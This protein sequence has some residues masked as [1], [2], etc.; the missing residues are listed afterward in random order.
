MTDREC[1]ELLQWA[2]PR[3]RLRWPGFRRV[4][5]Q[6]CKR[7]ARRVAV[8]GLPDTTA[9]RAHLEAN[10]AEWSALEACCWI[11]I[12]RFYRDRAVF[13]CLG[14]EL[15]PELASR[16][17]ARGQRVLHAWSAGCASGEEPYSLR[18]V[19]AFVAG[20]RLPGFELRIVA[21]DASAPLLARAARAVY[22]ESALKEL[23]SSWREGAFEPHGLAWQLRSEL[24][25]GVDFRR[26][27]LREDMPDG[28]FDLILCR[29]LAFTYFEEA[30]Q[31]ETLAALAQRLRPEGALVVGTHESPPPAPQLM[32]DLSRPWL[33]RRAPA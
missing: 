15:L 17:R 27:D 20:P 30:L 32:E 8:L 19:W 18:L 24:R 4:R 9:Y 22:T 12:S 33:R 7:I 1:V 21:T 5:R 25:S 26:Q 3:L 23:P 16:A 10:P 11:S 28:P 31:G 13:D 29:N 6:V 14:S 2:L